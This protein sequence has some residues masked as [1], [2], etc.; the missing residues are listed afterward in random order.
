MKAALAFGNKRLLSSQMTI[1]A[2]QGGFEDDN[3]LSS[4]PWRI[5][6]H[7]GLTPA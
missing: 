7:T 6:F 4:A 1:V 5:R 3:V 2:P